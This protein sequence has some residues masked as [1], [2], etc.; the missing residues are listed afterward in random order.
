MVLASNKSEQTL[1]LVVLLMSS[2][3]ETAPPQHIHLTEQKSLALRNFV[4][5]FDFLI[6]PTSPWDNYQQR[7]PL[8]PTRRG[9]G[10]LF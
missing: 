4:N 8:A 7:P 6:S 10:R 2:N 9:A 3:E 1:V 5:P